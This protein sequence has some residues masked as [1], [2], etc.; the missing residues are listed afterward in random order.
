MRKALRCGWLLVFCFPVLNILGQD[1]F[2]P[3]SVLSDDPWVDRFKR[4]WYSMVV[5]DLQEPSLL[6]EAANTQA[7]SYRFLWIRSFHHPIVVRLDLNPDG[8]GVLTTKVAT[9]AAGYPRSITHLLQNVT[10]PLPR[11]QIRAYLALLKKD[12]FW[13]LTSPDENKS[14]VDGAQWIV[15]GVQG[16]RYHV[17]DRWS[18]KEG[19]VRNLGLA[20][21]VGLAQMDIPDDE[22]Y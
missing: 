11:E 19:P 2:F 16:G 12:G 1:H 21:V 4:D 5:K 9:G 17:V 20:L 14:G 7:E 15:E 10:R 18:P 13:A 6:E 22:I 3:K 8:T